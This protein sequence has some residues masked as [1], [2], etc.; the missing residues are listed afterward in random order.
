VPI[1]S[2]VKLRIASPDAGRERLRQA[3]AMLVGARH[4]E[5]NQVY[6]DAALS[7]RGRGATLRLRRT[8]DGATFTYKGPRRMV[9]GVK[10]REERETRVADPDA[11]HATLVAL[12]FQAVFR[13]Q[14][15]R[16]TWALGDTEVVV[17]ETPIG[18][19]LEVEGKVAAIHG[20]ASALGFSP[21]DYLADSYVAL[22]F[23]SGGR[24]NMTFPRS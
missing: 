7:L 11:L 19:F 12:G 13:Y 4:L 15:Y 16:E 6:D 23:A 5:D 8:V 9:E 20:V 17:D 1:E 3:G 22:F 10:T 21:R 14:K 18:C 2:E 24:G